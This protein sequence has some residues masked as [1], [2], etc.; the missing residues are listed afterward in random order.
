MAGLRRRASENPATVLAGAAMLASGVL[1]LHWLSRLTFWRDEWDFLLH[2]RSWSPGTF[3]Q[4]FVEQLVAVSIFVYKVLAS[5]WGIESALPYQ[6]SYA[7][8]PP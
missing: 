2:R 8:D 6:V 7:I 4:P 1:L 5:T 3:F